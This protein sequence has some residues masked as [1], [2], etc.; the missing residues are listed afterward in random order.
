MSQSST[1]G[2]SLKALPAL[3]NTKVFFQQNLTRRT[4]SKTIA[5]LVGAGVEVALAACSARDTFSQSLPEG[6]NLYTYTG[7][8]DFV[9]AAAWSPNGQLIASG[10]ADGTVQVWNAVD[11]MLQKRYQLKPNVTALAWS[12][13]DGRYVA[14]GGDQGVA[15]VWDTTADIS[16]VTN[17]PLLKHD[18]KGHL[19]GLAWSPD[20]KMLALGVGSDRHVVEIY[21]I[22]NQNLIQVCRGNYG[23]IWNVAWSPDEKYIAAASQNNVIQVFN[24]ETAETKLVFSL[25]TGPVWGVDWSPDGKYI[26]SGG[27]DNNI[28]VW[29]ADTGH[30]VFIG[31]HSDIVY[32]VTWSP[33]GTSIASASRDRQVKVWNIILKSEVA[34]YNGHS[35]PAY[36]NSWSPEGKRLVSAYRDG[37]VQIWKMPF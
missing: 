22:Q 28:L 1:P 12:P 35:G 25:H 27:F 14:V 6:I 36:R 13:L 3:E 5:A 17:P 16:K 37:T 7:H 24:V 20:E 8:S 31:K 32:G 2:R 26:A 10:S 33:D 23:N 18:S 9:F 11:G 21:D 19:W 30:L 4:F 15:Y 34:V 29:D